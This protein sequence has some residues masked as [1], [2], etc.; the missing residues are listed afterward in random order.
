M[1]SNFLARLKASPVLCDGAMGTLLYSKGIFINR[2][3]DE[4]NVSQPDL[5]RGI[6]HE[7]LQ[8]GAEVIE[9]NTFGGNAIRL[10][11]HGL[12]DKVHE[13]NFHGAR[14]AKE[15]AKSFDAWVAG[16]VG[17]LGIRI[18]P[19]G[20]TSF[21][22]ARDIFREQIAALLEGG[23]D[24]LILETFGYIDELHQAIHA[25]RELDPRVPIVAQ[26][27]LDEESNCL[28]GSTPEIF[29]PR[30]EEWGADVIG[31]NCS[32]GP[33][34]MLDSVERIRAAT[35][36]PLSAQPNAG[37]PRSVE[38]RN[39]YL[40]SPEYMASY[41]RKFVTAGV[42]LVGGCCGSTPEHIRV[43]KSAL[44]ATQA[45]A[46]TEVTAKAQP[47]SPVVASTPL[48]Q[49]S[50]L[51]AKIA[52]GEFLT[53]V[54]IVPPKGTNIQK[55][56]E[57]AKFLKTVGVD[58]INIPDSPRASARMSNQ[59]LS[60]LLQQQAGIEAI[61]HYTCRDRNVL[62]IQS[63][64]LGA[65][66]IGIR[67]LICITGDPPKMGGYPD[68]TAVFDVDAI[69]LVNIVH[70][71]NRGLDIGGNPMGA[72]T[73]FVIGIGANP[74]VPN[75]DEEIRRFEY[76]VEAGAE[77]AVTQPVFDLSLLEA[78]LRRIEH[79]KIPV[80]AGIWPLV[81]ARNAEFMKN[82]LRVSV[83]ENI[84][85]RMTR[86]ASP[87]AAR[88]EGI[89]IARDMLIAVRHMVQGAQISAPQGKYASAV[90]VLEALGS[91]GARAG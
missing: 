24:I 64:L 21:Q 51:G 30:I 17:P 40:C 25:A 2:C 9:T 29:A 3:Y 46:R 34:T 88:E 37:I 20:K 47:A 16:A 75:I 12:R 56:L 76:K 72:G 74:G 4:L 82:E 83:P 70:N 6:H 32:V 86:A 44:R 26:V 68:A 62:C 33:V 27:T 80:V 57:G 50:R 35:T 71:L 48:E 69:G 85:E 43:M 78:F 81:S 15:A 61:L 54:E 89:S 87:E 91:S 49:R 63:D 38:G 7:Y 77:Y 65:A 1:P 10:E 66:A 39:I 22:E 55:E 52:R 73:G 18:E 19:L 67:N 84:M 90:D 8:A 28:D 31:C 11:R 42:R 60:L 13:I 79:F 45:R 59:A 14:L 23:V 5:I 41:A 58:A 53:M 36:L